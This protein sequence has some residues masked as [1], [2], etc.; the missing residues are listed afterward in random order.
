MSNECQ[1]SQ[2]LIGSDL[3]R[4]DP[5]FAGI[6]VQFVDGLSQRVATLEGAINAAD[7]DS[8]RT[9]AHQLKGSGGGYGYPALSDHAAKLESE[10]RERALE[11]CVKSV[12]QL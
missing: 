6:V 9:A 12:E 4:E 7:F 10:A 1:C 5:S 11:D 3:V 2:E 8:L